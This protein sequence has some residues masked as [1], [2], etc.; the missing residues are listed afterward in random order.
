MAKKLLAVVGSPR[1]GGNTDVLVDQ[2]LDA[3]VKKGGDSAKVV[4]SSLNIGPCTGCYACMKDKGL[5]TVCV[6]K[7]DMTGL[8]R[9]LFDADALLWATPIYMWSTTAQMKLFLDRLFPIGD[10]QETRW[11][12]ALKGKRLGI[13]IVYNETDSLQSGV[14]QTRDVL[15]VVAESSGAEVDFV[16]HSIVGEKGDTLKNDDLVQRVRKAAAGLYR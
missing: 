9:E 12:S 7:D 8:Y 13:L 3:F 15:K 11:R 16:I 4:L 1:K 14:S 6:L 2:A 10:Y 5:E